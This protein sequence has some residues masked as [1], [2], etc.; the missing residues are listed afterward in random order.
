MSSK[1]TKDYPNATP[2][3]YASDELRNDKKIVLAA[4]TTNG[5]AL[6]DASEERQR[7]PEIV[8]AA[9][10]Q[11]DAAWQFVPSD[12]KRDKGFVLGCLKLNGMMLNYFSKNFHNKEA[13][14]LT[15]VKQDG[16]ALQFASDTMKKNIKIVT[17]AT[18]NNGK[19][20]AHAS[21]E[22]KTN[23]DVVLAALGNYGPAI[24]FASKQMKSD[25]AFMLNVVKKYGRALEHSSKELK[26]DK[27]IVL[28]A[29]TQDGTA[30]SFARESICA[31]KIIVM[32]AV[33]QNKS[34][35]QY[36]SDDLKRDREVVMAACGLLLS[37]PNI[38]PIDTVSDMKVVDWTRNMQT[39]CKYR[40]QAHRYISKDYDLIGLT[41]NDTFQG[42]H[43]L[44]Q[45]VN[46]LQ[47]EQA[48]RVSNTSLFGDIAFALYELD[49]ERTTAST[50]RGCAAGVRQHAFAG[51]GASVNQLL[52]DDRFPDL[53]PKMLFKL[54]EEKVKMG[55]GRPFFTVDKLKQIEDELGTGLY[56]EHYHK[57]NNCFTSHKETKL[58]KCSRC[59]RAWYCVSN[60]CVASDWPRHKVHE[61][62][63]KWRKKVLRLPSRAQY[64]V[65][66]SLIEKDIENNGPGISIQVDG[67]TQEPIVF[68][69]DE[70][71]NE[72]FDGLTDRVV[73]FKKEKSDGE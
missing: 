29:V 50:L 70:V 9:V 10:M 56:S 62:K 45:W 54:V 73:G 37:S 19:A 11:N 52:Y 4:V 27:E 60:D 15:A 13:I 5:L 69:W 68:C 51:F 33:S 47:S 36:A 14:V 31:D 43:R 20:L 34:A 3:R 35:L 63:E 64:M 55:A 8:V 21:R 2:L 28:A 23:K 65:T 17:A 32:A 39:Q 58:E 49:D 25:K 72:M 42:D 12:A 59:K 40:Y 26:I 16:L 46:R 6:K 67:K 66:K 57:C 18:K 48:Q 53:V 1:K 38:V 22:M 41:I 71:K 44:L 24:R 30:L 7:D 61:C